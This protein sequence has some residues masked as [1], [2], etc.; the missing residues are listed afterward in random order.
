MNKT[1]ILKYFTKTQ[2]R[3]PSYLML[4]FI[5]LLFFRGGPLTMTFGDNVPLVM[6]EGIKPHKTLAMILFIYS[7]LYLFGV[8][9]YFSLMGLKNKL[10][11]KEKKLNEEEEINKEINEGINY[12]CY[13]T[14]DL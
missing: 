14:K 12:E 1:K 8:A 3:L 13:K 10:F 5:T 2:S 6:L 4:L 9:D 7:P 11:P